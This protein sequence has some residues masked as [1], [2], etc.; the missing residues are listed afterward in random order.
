MKKKIEDPEYEREAAHYAEPIASRRLILDVMADIGEPIGF[1][2]LAKELDLEQRSQRKALTNRL[3]AMVRAGQLAVDRRNVYAIASKMELVRGRISGH[4]GGYG[5]L[6]TESGHDDVFLSHRQM[7]GVFHGDIA[8]VRVR[9]R[10]RR[11]RPE[12]ELV[13]VLERNTNALV[14]RLYC[15][16]GTWLLESLN[17]RITQEIMLDPRGE[18]REGLIVIA[19]IIDQPSIHGVATCF[20]REVL[21]EHLSTEME[22]K[23]SL[24]NHDIPSEFA[25]EVIAEASAIPQEIDDTDVRCDLREL[26]FVTIDG[27][28]ARDFDDAIYCEHRDKGGWRLIVAI[29]D[30]AHYVRKG[31]ALD[32]SALDRGTSVYF[33]GSVIPML[34]TVL[35][36]ELC[37]LKPG[38]DRLVLACDMQISAAGR[39]SGYQF[40]EG[41]ICSAARLTYEEVAAGASEGP[42]SGSLA[43]VSGLVT[44]L[45][46]GREARGAL[47]FDTVEL[48]FDLDDS[49]SIR[50]IRPKPRNDA[51][52]LIEE[53]MLCANVCAARFMHQL[54]LAGMYRVH[55]RPDEEKLSN[56]RKFLGSIGINLTEDL[57]SPGELQTV[58]D[59]LRD[60]P[61]GHILQLAVL[62]SLSQ[63]VYQTY[64]VGHYGLNFAMYTHFTSPIRRYPD[65]MTHRLIKSV[66]YGSNRKN[67]VRRFGAKKRP[68]YDYDSD[69]LEFIAER[70]SSTER[71][72]ETAVY[73]VL[74]W[75]KC[76]YLAGKVGDTAPGVITHV[77]SFGFFVQLTELYVE[78][79]VHVSN[80]INDYY[81]FDQDQQCLIGEHIGIS[82]GIGDSVSV[83]IAR[84]DVDEQKVDFELVFHD[85]LR[86]RARNKPGKTKTSGAGRRRRRR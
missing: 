54:E 58:L 48:D 32:D 85:P 23:M 44:E 40:Y 3:R 81:E 46:R 33:P 45:L 27:A 84:V 64:N 26:P 61:N 62:R 38:V 30:V 39:I 29:A 4:T 14:G 75:M 2:R 16:N 20:V 11:G 37:S 80:L 72:A 18:E 77:T 21:G 73:E 51:M 28:D 10:D 5:F 56:L 31:S 8:Q 15:D 67:S 12:G 86:R 71:R 49:G 76:E 52:R 35:S 24:L 6:V 74:E 63:A 36:N 55:E 57:P 41:V 22:I 79:L 53:C 42:W 82:F 68:E 66:I 43:A 69:S 59:Q 13:D 25:D 70:C 65:L 83:Q 47:D 60:K 17:P 19:E 7:R 1:K 34:P 9:G 50:S 78:G